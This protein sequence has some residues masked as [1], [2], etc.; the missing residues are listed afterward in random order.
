MSKIAVAFWQNL[1]EEDKEL[2]SSIVKGLEST[3]LAGFTRVVLLTFQ[4]FL[5]TPE[6]ITVIDARAI[7][8]YECFKALY[9]SG[10]DNFPVQIGPG[11]SKK[12]KHSPVICLIADVIRFKYAAEVTRDQ[13]DCICIIDCDT[14]WLQK[15]T[16]VGCLGFNFASVIQ[17]PS[18]LLNRNMLQRKLGWLQRYGRVPGDKLR[19]SFPGQF[20]TGHPVLKTIIGKIEHLCPTTGQFPDV[21]DWD[22]VMKAFLAGI[23]EHGLRDA[24][25]PHHAFSPVPWYWR[26]K[27]F[28]AEVGLYEHGSLVTNWTQGVGGS[29]LFTLCW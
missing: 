23:E 28:E 21:K 8:P 17:N 19:L 12:V 15:W 14:L 3:Q 18:S 24:I 4:T 9:Q 16:S 26:Q 29:N 10:S 6:H 27:P 7:M 22:V 25:V 11:K 2:P 5:N 1:D 20:V 13:C